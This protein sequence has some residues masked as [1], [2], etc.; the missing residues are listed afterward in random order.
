[1][2]N[3]ADLSSLINLGGTGSVKGTCYITTNEGKEP[4]GS[5]SVTV[6]DKTVTSNTDGTFLVTG[7]KP[8]T[9]DIR[10]SGGDLGY[11]GKVTVT[12]GAT[13]EMGELQLHGTLPPPPSDTPGDTLPDT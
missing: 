10:V 2:S 1:L 4:V 7:L 9:Y 6:G 8:G 3:L 12:A 5:L 13:A 11:T